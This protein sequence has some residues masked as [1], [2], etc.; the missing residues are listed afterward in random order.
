MFKWAAK[1][2]R[3]PDDPTLGVTREKAKSMGYKTWSEDQIARHPT[4]AGRCKAGVRR[5]AA[6][7]EK[8]F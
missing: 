6:T 3:V 1:E 8:N 5:Q 2:G 4:D 7:R